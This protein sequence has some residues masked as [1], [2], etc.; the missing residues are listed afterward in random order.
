V[1]YT[2]RYV[3]AD[4]D[5]NG[6]AL[7]RGDLVA[8]DIE[9]MH[10]RSDL[11]DAPYEFRPERFLDAR[12]GTFTWIPFGGGIHRCIGAGFALTEARLILATILGRFSFTATGR[13]EPSRR[14]VL[15]TVPAR[16][17]TVTLARR[18]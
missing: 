7:K 9:R 1:P 5:L 3:E 14:T 17:A 11:Y 12:P 2:V 15:V 16:G 8:L 10:L 18:A 13:S 6:V 4:F